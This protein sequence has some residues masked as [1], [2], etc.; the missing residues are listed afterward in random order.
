[1]SSI[2]RW[3]SATNKVETQP[4]TLNAAEAHYPSVSV[5][6]PVYNRA[7]PIQACLA[8]LFAQTY[9]QTRYEI[10]VVDDG[11][12]D[13]TAEQV[14]QS[15]AAWNGTLRLLQKKNAG[16]ASARNAGIRASEAEVIAFIDSDCLASPD[17]L[18]SLLKVLVTSDASG[19]GGPLFDSSPQGWVAEYLHAASFFRHRVRHGQ[20][21]YLL[22]ANVAFRRA[23]LLALHGFSERRGAWCEDADLSFRLTQAGYRLLLAEQGIVTH[24]GTPESIR[25]LSKHLYRYGYGNVMLS[26]HWKNGRTPLVEFIR[27]GGAV[28]L[29]PVLALSYRRA[30]GIRQACSFWPLI[31]IE[32]VSFIAGLIGALVQKMIQGNQWQ[33]AASS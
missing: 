25:D 27:H 2:R 12:T 24:Y 9:P 7:A 18:E 20:V 28:I 23:A 8:S 29:S 19:V 32:H 33:E 16:P 31:I 13:D 21:E 22:T 1:M 5:V 3:M 30:V 11:S 4:M 10:I 15:A 6:I 26:P 14:R 17:W